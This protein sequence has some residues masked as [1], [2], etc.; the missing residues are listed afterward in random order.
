M[1]HF[2]TNREWRKYKCQTCIQLN[3]QITKKKTDS[4]NKSRFTNGD[5]KMSEDSITEL[6]I[7]ISPFTFNK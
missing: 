3:Q 5:K 2:Y 1:V 4:S 6:R 7:N